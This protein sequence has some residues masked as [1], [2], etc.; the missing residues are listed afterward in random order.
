MTLKHKVH[1]IQLYILI[2]LL[3]YQIPIIGANRIHYDLI[4]KISGNSKNI[5]LNFQD[6]LDF[7]VGKLNQFLQNF[8]VNSL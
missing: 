6:I 1:N 5:R 7:C 8:I 2:F 3:C 4:I